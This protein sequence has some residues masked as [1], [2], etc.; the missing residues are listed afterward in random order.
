M[1]PLTPAAGVWI[2]PPESR[3]TFRKLEL[4][5]DTPFVPQVSHPSLAQ[6]SRQPLED[7]LDGSWNPQILDRRLHSTVRLLSYLV[8]GKPQERPENLILVS[9]VEV[10][11]QLCIQIGAALEQVR[12]MMR[13]RGAETGQPIYAHSFL[14]APERSA[15]VEQHRDCDIAAR[16]LSEPWGKNR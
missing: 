11:V 15:L 13:V 8:L 9:T 2:N 16:D 5:R 12:A 10:L 4:P 6:R 3:P 7:L 1:Q 14:K